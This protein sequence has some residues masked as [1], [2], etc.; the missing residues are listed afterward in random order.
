MAHVL[1]REHDDHAGRPQRVGRVQAEQAGVRLGGADE[2]DMERAGELGQT[3]AVD[4]RAA[5]GDERRVLDAQDLALAHVDGAAAAAAFLAS[6]SAHQ[7]P[8]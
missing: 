6:C 1:A 2:G 4:E 3:Q 5:P 7:S 8:P